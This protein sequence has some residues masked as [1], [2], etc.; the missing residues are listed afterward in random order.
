[1]RRI[2]SAQGQSTAEYAVVIAFV[3]AAVIG[4]QAFVKRGLQGK[5]KDVST[6]LQNATGTGGDLGGLTSLRQ[7]EPYYA[8]QNV[9]THLTD[10]W[11][12]E[13]KADDEAVRTGIVS[14]RERQAGSKLEETGFSDPNG[15]W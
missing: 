11:S 7:Y 9:K 14:G 2:L 8:K 1:M 3:L 12:E 5:Y 4:M 13:M 15:D 6:E 10:N